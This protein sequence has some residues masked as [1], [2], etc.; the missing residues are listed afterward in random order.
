MKRLEA[1]EAICRTMGLA[2]VSEPGFIWISTPE[3][4]EQESTWEPDS[5]FGDNRNEEALNLPVSIQFK[6]IF[7]DRF[8]SLFISKK[9]FILKAH[10][11]KVVFL[12]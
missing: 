12:P 1:I 11:I 6:K 7:S 5:R 10:V 8:S 2:M 9:S 4:I 3:L